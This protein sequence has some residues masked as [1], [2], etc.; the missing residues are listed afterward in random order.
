MAEDLIH[1]FYFMP[2][3]RLRLVLIGEAGSHQMLG[4]AR[5]D[6]APQFSILD[7]DAVYLMLERVRE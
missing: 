6:C 3:F 4:R 7:G 1:I 5:Q 2:V